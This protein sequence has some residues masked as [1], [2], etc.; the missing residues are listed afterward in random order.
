MSDTGTA[1]A[2]ATTADTTA[3]AATTTTAAAATTPAAFDWGQQGL[4]ADSSTYVASKGWK[5]PGDLLASYRGAEK[6]IGVPPE[7]VVKIPQG[8]FNQEVYN[9]QVADRL[10]RPKEASGYELTKLVPAG[11]DTKFAET[12]QG[13]FHELGLTARQAQ[14]LTKWWN[15]QA[16]EMTAA[17]S[18]AAKTRNTQ[19]ISSLK[20]EW[21]QSWD[22]NAA[23][24]DKAAAEFGMKPEQ[25]EALKVSMGAA[26]AMKFLHTIGSKLGVS[27]TFVTGDS[28]E[29]NFAGGMTADQ[30]KGQIEGLKKDKAF[31]A[32]YFA[33]D[34]EA[35]RKMTDLHMRAAPGTLT[36]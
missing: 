32:K 9:T 29:G 22:S 8:E 12:A 10:G 14:E 35:K 24:V 7:S 26:G 36:L 23:L 18:E 20:A 13:K 19:E 30:A 4:D 28:R 6:L 33:G 17:Q 2:T 25:V 27:D 34:A 16:G 15:G 1:A 31:M 21:G 3:A 11:Q 5:T